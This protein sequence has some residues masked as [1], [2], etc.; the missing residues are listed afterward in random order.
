MWLV[1]INPRQTTYIIFSLSPSNPTATLVIN[2]Q[3]MPKEDNPTYLG[4]TFEKRMTWKQQTEKAETRRKKASALMKKIA[5]KTFAAD[6]GVLIRC[7]P[8]E[9]DE[10]LNTE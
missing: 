4:V 7:K 5:G 8:E 2:G 9:S 10:C 1:K 6:V 3:T